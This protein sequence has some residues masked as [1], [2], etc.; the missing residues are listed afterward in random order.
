MK[1]INLEGVKNFW[2]KRPDQHKK[3]SLNAL[4]LF[5]ENKQYLEYI[6]STEMWHLKKII[7]FNNKPRVL[8]LGCGV[9][10]EDFEIADDCSEI[11]AF[12]YSKGFIELAKKRAKKKNITNIKFG[13]ADITK[14][15]PMGLFDIV[16]ITGTFIYLRDNQM[17]SVIKLI[18]KSLRPGGI[19][20]SREATASNAHF[21]R[22]DDYDEKFGCEYNAVYRTR[23]DYEMA[24][25]EKKLKNT[26]WN[27][28]FC[29]LNLG[30]AVYKICGDRPCA[31]LLVKACFE[32]QKGIDALFF[33]KKTMF[34]NYVKKKY[35]KIQM[36]YLYQ[37][38]L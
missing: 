28:L 12:D 15:R 1:E 35:K 3:T 30:L 20:F 2:E 31:Q 7:R 24:F 36:V 32:V 33:N 14:L 4:T 29:P 38:G 5:V 11:I 19:V 23:H 27:Y 16:I 18:S 26:Y 10:R 6:N 21:S 34:K 9:G 25:A 37:H 13:V 17:R 22:I 8:D